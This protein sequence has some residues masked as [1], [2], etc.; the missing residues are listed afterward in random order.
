MEP[1]PLWTELLSPR[2]SISFVLIDLQIYLI[3]SYLSDR[4]SAWK[5][6]GKINLLACILRVLFS[7]ISVPEMDFL[8]SHRVTKFEVTFWIEILYIC[9]LTLLTTIYWFVSCF[10][11]IMGSSYS[12]CNELRATLT[13]VDIAGLFHKIPSIF[14]RTKSFWAMWLICPHAFISQ[15]LVK[16]VSVCG[17]TQMYDKCISFELLS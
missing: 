3:L 7:V 14:A 1:L 10:S 15:R 2:A 16:S 6:T 4:V 17:G 13:E 8:I 12:L 11:I 9:V 5:C